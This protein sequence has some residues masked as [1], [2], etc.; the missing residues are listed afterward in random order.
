MDTSAT[1]STSAA[2]R[3]E[4]KVYSE[5]DVPRIDE[6]EDKGNV[7]YYLMILFGIGAL[8]PWNAVLTALDF[9]TEKVNL[10]S[11]IENSLACRISACIRLW[12]RSQQLTYL[13]L[14]FHNHLRPQDFL[15]EKDIWRLPIYCSPH[16]HLTIGCK[17]FRSHSRFLLL[18]GSSL[19]LWSN[20][21]YRSR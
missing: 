13:H 17:L 18:L 10:D 16:D 4:I 12:L 3:I 21:W 9:F 2:K 11:I 6:P 19:L 7:A 14:S 15:F 5:S 8:L 1:D 20:R